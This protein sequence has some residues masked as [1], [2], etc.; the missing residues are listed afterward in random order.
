MKRR[1]LMVTALAGASALI[2]PASAQ[3]TRGSKKLPELIIGDDKGNDFAL[4]QKD[5]EL[6]SPQSYRWSLTSKATKEMAFMAPEFFRNVW[7]NQIVVN[8]L[9]VHMAGAPHHL[10]FDAPGTFSI[11]F[12]TIRPGDYEW[13]I[14]GLKDKGMTGKIVIK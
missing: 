5:F 13:W 2:A 6:I 7:M 1:T 9:E 4:S 10:E 3:T 8:D 12:A 11:Q 14:E